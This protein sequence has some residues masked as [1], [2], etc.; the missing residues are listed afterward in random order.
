MSA[1]QTL[2]VGVRAKVAEPHWHTVALEL[3]LLPPCVAAGVWVAAEGVGAL[4]ALLLG[5]E[6]W[7]QAR[8]EVF[9]QL[10]LVGAVQL[11]VAN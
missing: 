9:L 2:L 10:E 3:L 1:V 6:G 5:L 11:S 7:L 4:S 8:P